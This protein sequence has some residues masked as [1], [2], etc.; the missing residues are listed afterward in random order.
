[1]NATGGPRFWNSAVTHVTFV[2][3]G[4][5]V[6]FLLYMHTYRCSR[7][8]MWY[9][10]GWLSVWVV[11]ACGQVTP[12]LRARTECGSVDGSVQQ[13]RRQAVCANL[14]VSARFSN[15]RVCF[16]FFVR[17]AWE[18][19]IRA[20]R[21]VFFHSKA[22]YPPRPSW[23]IRFPWQSVYPMR[24]YCVYPVLARLFCGA[25]WRASLFF[26]L[27]LECVNYM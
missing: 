7:N 11:C 14:A 15:V 5:R 3:I 2:C 19:Y 18:D 8:H 24:V 13:T 16:R 21:H 22:G 27:Y 17:C 23:K 10:F 12:E 20:E 9:T 25:E 4:R 1:M 6:D 26:F